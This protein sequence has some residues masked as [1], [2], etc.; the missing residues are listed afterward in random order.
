MH[1]GKYMHPEDWQ[2]M[3]AAEAVTETVLVVDVIVPEGVAQTKPRRTRTP[4]KQ[5]AAKAA[6]ADAMGTDDVSAIDVTGLD[7]E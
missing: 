7:A 6:I 3:K 4:N 2:A 1:E 5:Q